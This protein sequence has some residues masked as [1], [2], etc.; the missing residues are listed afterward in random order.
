MR[1]MSRSIL[2]ALGSAWL[3]CGCAGHPVDCAM[4]VYHADC[5]P[6]S[7][8]YVVEHTQATAHVEQALAAAQNICTHNGYSRNTTQWQHCVDEQQKVL[9]QQES[10]SSADLAR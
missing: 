4:G 8:A 5:G 6:G 9:L 7:R 1:R 3:L 2:M 10:H